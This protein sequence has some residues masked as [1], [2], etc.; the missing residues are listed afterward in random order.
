VLETAPAVVDKRKSDKRAT[1]A[2]GKGTRK[3]EKYSE[4]R[5]LPL[6]IES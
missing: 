5:Q 3:N 1:F 4:K 6:L 2:K